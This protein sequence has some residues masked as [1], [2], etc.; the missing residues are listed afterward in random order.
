[1][2]LAFLACVESG[3]LEDQGL[4]LFRS[5]RRFAGRYAAS[6]IVCFTP[7]A[8]APLRPATLA[9]FRELG[10]EH[11]AERLNVEF[12]GDP[13]TNKIFAG[14][15]AERHRDEDV[16]VFLDSDTIVCGEPS[17]L[18][19]AAGEAAALRP[20][21]RKQRGS[22]GPGDPNEPY[23]E[24]L[25]ALLGVEPGPFVTTTVGSERI[26]AFWNSGLVALRRSERIFAH[27]L[28]DYMV[29]VEEGH[30]PAGARRAVEQIAL[31][32]A[33][34]RVADRV[35]VLDPRH[36]YPLPMRDELADPWRA[37]PLESLVHVH[38]FRWFQ[39]PGFLDRLVPP[40]DPGGAV[41]R[42]L[43]AFLPLEPVDE[44]P[45]RGRQAGKF[46]GAPDPG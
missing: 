9:G 44:N 6:P 2:S 39:M 24:K 41:T 30:V 33:L 20:V 29:L 28:H 19:L 34:C 40:L 18:A 1:M 27:W 11:V 45:G 37:A 8:G 36:N 14:A 22:T 12:T 26:R 5:I 7:R 43:A 10:V 21:N 16:L 23:W 31:A 15:W 46:R 42:W 25:Y 3:Y 32:G 13:L 35:R 38:Y 4:L 17:D